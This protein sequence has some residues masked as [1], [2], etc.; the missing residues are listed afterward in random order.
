[1]MITLPNIQYVSVH[2]HDFDRHFHS[3]IICSWTSHVDQLIDPD[4]T[5][6]TDATD[7]DREI[8]SNIRS[9]YDAWLQKLDS[10]VS[11]TFVPKTHFWFPREDEALREG[12]F[13]LICWKS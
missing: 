3:N 10:I 9:S 5:N 12:M 7:I 2:A 1:M 8:E 4:P 6:P 11:D 13:W